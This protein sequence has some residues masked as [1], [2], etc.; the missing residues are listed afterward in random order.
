MD[1]TS[2]TKKSKTEENEAR[3]DYRVHVRAPMDHPAQAGQQCG[4][5]WPCWVARPY[6]L[7]VA[8]GT[9]VPSLPAQVRAILR[10]RDFGLFIPFLLHILGTSSR[11]F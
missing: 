2:S 7:A 4:M 5:A 1:E 9:V 10:F 11:P 3:V 8:L 6:H